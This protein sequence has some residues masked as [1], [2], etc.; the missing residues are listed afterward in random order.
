MSERSNTRDAFFDAT[1]VPSAAKPQPISE[2]LTQRRKGRK[3]QRLRLKI[4]HKSF[5]FPSKLGVFCALAGA[6]LRIDSGRNLSRSSLSLGMTAPGRHLASLRL[7]ASKSSSSVPRK[8]LLG[9][10]V[11]RCA[12]F[13][14]EPQDPHCR[15]KQTF[16]MLLDLTRC[17]N[18]ASPA[19]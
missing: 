19:E 10:L 16:A 14:G 1:D 11:R 8:Q 17:P 12:K 4:I 6:K 3:D 15:R 5:I 2:Y 9:H 13:S 7:G 18:P